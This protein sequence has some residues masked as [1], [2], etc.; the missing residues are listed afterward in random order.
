MNCRS[1]SDFDRFSRWPEQL[2][3]EV[4]DA[5]RALAVAE[6]YISF[7]IQKLTTRIASLSSSHTKPYTRHAKLSIVSSRCCALRQPDHC[8]TA[9]QN[10]NTPDGRHD[11]GQGYS[12]VGEEGEHG[13]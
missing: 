7:W 3:G 6:H 13:R 8:N 11:D 2:V 4:D 10:G 1:L 9:T 12:G 5:Q